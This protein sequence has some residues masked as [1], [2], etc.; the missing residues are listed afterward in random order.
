MAKRIRTFIAVDPSAAVQQQLVALQ[1]ELRELEEEVKW[2]EPEN[3]HITIKF[4]GDVDETD[5]YA[6]CKMAERAVQEIPPFSME[7]GTVGAF[8]SVGRP[9]VLWVGVRQGAGELIKIHDKVEELFGEQGYRSE[10]RAFTPHLTLGRVRHS[11]PAPRLSTTLRGL[12]Q[13]QGGITPV[14]E[15]LVMASQ[16]SANGPTHTVMGRGRLAGKAE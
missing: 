2:V 7:M 13:W 14:H 8:P 9:R 15:N 12:A 10:D 5:L 1:D 16:L 3:L 11:G 4:L 6:I